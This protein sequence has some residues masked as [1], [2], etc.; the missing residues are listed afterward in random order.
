MVL[1]LY[2]LQ[3]RSFA[4]RIADLVKDEVSEDKMKKTKQEMLAEVSLIQ[5]IFKF[6]LFN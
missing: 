1:L 6:N 5:E 2:E 3:M 4:K